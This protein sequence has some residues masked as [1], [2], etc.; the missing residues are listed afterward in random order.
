MTTPTSD[1]SGL[2]VM[3]PAG[4]RVVPAEPME[5]MGLDEPILTPCSMDG[6]L[7]GQCQDGSWFATEAGEWVGS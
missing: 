2:P 4:V 6:W 5:V 7:F 1:K 3:F